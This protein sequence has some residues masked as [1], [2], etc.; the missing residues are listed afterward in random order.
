MASLYIDFNREDLQVFK[1]LDQELLKRKRLIFDR[2][3]IYMLAR[4][5]ENFDK[6]RDIY[7]KEFAP[8]KPRKNGTNKPLVKSAV[9]QNSFTVDEFK[10]GI[11]IKST[12][13]YA[14]FHNDGT[15]KIKQRQFLPKNNLPENYKRDILAIIENSLIFES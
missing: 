6:S 8:I 15:D 3:G 2:V 7:M 1:K 9:L 5:R 10:E 13:Y 11:V 12:V 14:S 4:T